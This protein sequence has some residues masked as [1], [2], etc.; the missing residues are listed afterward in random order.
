MQDVFT[1]YEKK[2]LITKGQ[3]ASL[4]AALNERMKPD[5]YDSYW[6]QNLYFDTE[7]WDVIHTS[8]QRPYYKEKMRLR[9]YGTPDG[10]SEAYLELKKKYAGVVYKRRIALPLAA[11]TS[12]L[13]EVLASHQTQIAKELDFYL[14]TNKVSQKM[15]V[16]YRRRAF[17]CDEHPGLRLTLDT[18]IRYRSD[19]LHFQEPNEGRIVLSD[20][21]QLMEI[22]FPA[23]I[24]LWLARLCS[25]NGIFATTYSKYARCFTNYVLL[26]NAKK[27]DGDDPCKSYYPPAT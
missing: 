5:L 7:N 13:E 18:D 10:A 20:D 3:A 25:E 27:K 24:P 22:K 21:Y 14:R 2:F 23:S 1:R 19:E 12:P 17:S 15:F 9:Y 4:V 11:I 26:E 16:A 6:V 8:M